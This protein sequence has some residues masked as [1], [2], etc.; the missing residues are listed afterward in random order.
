MKIQDGTSTI[1]AITSLQPVEDDHAVLLFS[2][3]NYSSNITTPLINPLA[4]LEEAPKYD[5]GSQTCVTQTTVEMTN[6]SL[7][8]NLEELKPNDNKIPVQSTNIGAIIQL[9]DKS[10]NHF[11]TLKTLSKNDRP[12]FAKMPIDAAPQSSERL[13]VSEQ[14][15]KNLKTDN[16]KALVKQDDPSQTSALPIIP[17]F[18]IQDNRILSQSPG[19]CLSRSSD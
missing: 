12:W 15:V 8:L 10:A 19:K 18:I 5:L 7:L 4:Y 2:I 1:S 6:E 14:L 3:N 17:F 16:D 13:V 9:N 11:H